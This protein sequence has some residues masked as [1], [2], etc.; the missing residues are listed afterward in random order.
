MTAFPLNFIWGVSTSAYQTEGAWNEDGK[1]PS[2]WDDFCHEGGH[3]ADGSTGDIACDSYH[4]YMEDI[5]AMKLLGIKIARFSISW[6]RVIPAGTWKINRKGL[7]FYITLARAL[8]ENGIKPMPTLFHWDLPSKLMEKGGYASPDFP[9]WFLEYARIMIEALHPYADMF[10]TFNQPYSI[11]RS[12][13]SKLRAPALGD[14]KSAYI[15]GN[16][17]LFAH[18]L[19]TRMIREQ[20]PGIKCGI[21]V[22]LIDYEAA[23]GNDEDMHAC[24][25]QDD[26]TNMQFISPLLNGTYPDSIMSEARKYGITKILEDRERLNIISEPMD[27]IGINYYQRMIVGSG[28]I[29][30][31]VQ[32]HIYTDG[33]REIYPE[34]LRIVA[35]RVHSIAPGLDIFITENGADYRK[36]GLN[37]HK[38]IDYLRKHLEVVSSMIASGIPIRGYFLWTLM[39]NFE[40]ENGYR[41]SYG[42]FALTEDLKRIPKKSA[43]WYSNVVSKNM[44]CQG[45]F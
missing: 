21:V 4:R 5:E 31:Y 22:N 40:W 8:K 45:G 41:G 19:V 35:E 23:S 10:V 30:P 6:P 14:L 9:S 18:G 43:L 17:V 15:S 44:L 12:V 3:I 25:F 29:I 28:G 32:G 13:A 7:D 37:D 38:R 24:S 33:G 27:F 36:E 20:F 34:G 26:I 2:I 16:N 1:G 42:V 11:F 39:D